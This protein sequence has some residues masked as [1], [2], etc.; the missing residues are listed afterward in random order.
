MPVPGSFAS[1]HSPVPSSHRSVF[2]PIV[3]IAS[4]LRNTSLESSLEPRNVDRYSEAN[5]SYADHA[6]WPSGPLSNLLYDDDSRQMDQE[7]ASEDGVDRKDASIQSDDWPNGDEYAETQDEPNVSTRGSKRGHG[8]DDDLSTATKKARG[9]R[10]R[11]VSL[12]QPWAIDEDMEVD[13]EDELMDEVPEMRSP[14]IRGKKRDREEAASTFGGDDESDAEPEDSAVLRRRQ[15]KRRTVAKRQSEASYLRG[16]KRDREGNENLSDEEVLELSPVMKKKRGKRPALVDQN[17]DGDFSMDE[18]TTSRSSKT[19]RSIG[20]EWESNG[21]R[22]KI[23]PNGQRLRQALVKKAR[24]K[25]SMVS[26]GRLF[27]CSSRLSISYSPKTRSILTAM[28][29]FRSASNVG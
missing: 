2:S 11:K 22:W 26:F 14:N 13:N 12:E 4:S 3:F 29:I 20:D 25:F 19:R 10:A 27:A 18:S 23:G 21:I 7:R 16:K 24:Q 17:Q 28:R 6:P 8:E 5:F 15:R 1:H 9:K